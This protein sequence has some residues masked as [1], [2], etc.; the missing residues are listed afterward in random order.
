LLL[1]S[2]FKPMQAEGAASPMADPRGQDFVDKFLASDSI[3]QSMRD[4]SIAERFDWVSR[5][6]AD[7][8]AIHDLRKTLSYSELA[9]SVG[10]VRA[11]GERYV[12]EPCGG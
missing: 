4:G 5:R 2:K 1:D 6:Y 7:R 3:A 12:F 8:L 9:A 11:A 10:R